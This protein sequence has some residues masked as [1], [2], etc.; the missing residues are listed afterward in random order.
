MYV[1]ADAND[2]MVSIR[3]YITKALRV[4]TCFPFRFFS[5]CETF[6][7]SHSSFRSSGIPICTRNNILNVFVVILDVVYIASTL[8]YAFM[9]KIYINTI[10]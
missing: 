7:P 5:H 1:C 3:L 6:Y 4:Y 2:N 9:Y 8:K 10:H